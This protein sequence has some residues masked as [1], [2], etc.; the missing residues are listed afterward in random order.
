MILSHCSEDEDKL[1]GLRFGL[2]VP[3]ETS[4]K[5]VDGEQI[6]I[7]IDSSKLHFFDP[8]TGNAI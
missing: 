8:N 2:E 3:L 4:Q 7:S 1:P 6:K 5:I